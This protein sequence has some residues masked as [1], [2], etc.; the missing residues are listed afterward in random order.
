MIESANQVHATREPE[1]TGEL[2]QTVVDKTGFEAK[3]LLTVLA[4]PPELKNTLRR[5]STLQYV[6]LATG[7]GLIVFGFLAWVL[8]AAVYI[9]IALVVLGALCI[10]LAVLIRI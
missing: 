10:A 5:L 3:D 7:L 2:N 6:V 9:G 4:K 8:L 1:S